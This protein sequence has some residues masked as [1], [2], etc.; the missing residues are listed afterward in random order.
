MNADTAL[1]EAMSH[2]GI[3]S[4]VWDRPVGDGLY[5]KV[6]VPTAIVERLA[7]RGYVIVAKDTLSELLD[8]YL[9]THGPDGYPHPMPQAWR[10]VAARLREGSAS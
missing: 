6:P 8:D 10:E 1:A 3:P 9:A 2:F 7:E 5:R 4:M